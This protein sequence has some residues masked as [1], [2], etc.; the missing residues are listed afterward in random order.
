MAMT[1]SELRMSLA[2]NL[3]AMGNRFPKVHVDQLLELHNRFHDPNERSPEI[4]KLRELLAAMDRAVLDAYGWTD[5][6]TD[7][8][9]FLDYE[10]DE[11]TWGTKKKP[12]RYRWPDAVHDEVLARLLELNQVRAQAEARP[13]VTATDQPKD[14]TDPAPK[15]AKADASKAKKPSRKKK[16]EATLPMFGA[17][18]TKQKS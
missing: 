9:F 18:D 16:D 5:I 15:A 17:F 14:K 4:L 6:P 1:N 3:V 8:D 11:E 10:I 13:A 12:Y 7:C 2:R